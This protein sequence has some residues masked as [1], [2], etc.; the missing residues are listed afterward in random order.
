[1]CF[2]RALRDLA[3]GIDGINL[4]HIPMHDAWILELAAI[5]GEVTSIDEPLIYYRQTGENV[6][7][8]ATENATDKVARNSK[9]LLAGDFLARKKAFINE[10]KLF[11]RELL[12]IP[13]LPADKKQVLQ[14]FVTIDKKNKFARMHFYKKNNFTRARHNLWM[15]LWV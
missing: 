13:D 1:M 8:A 6:M 9:N 2:N 5:F 3:T 10:A 12:R 14:D 4:E 15:R 11:A 7:G